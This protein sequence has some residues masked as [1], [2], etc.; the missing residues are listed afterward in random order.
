MSSTCKNCGDSYK[1]MN[2]DVKG[3]CS[4]WCREQFDEE[5]EEQIFKIEEL[6]KRIEKLEKRIH[7]IQEKLFGPN[8]I[9]LDI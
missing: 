2:S 8:Y 3:F 5:C 7:A 4:E 6:E 1:T 9:L